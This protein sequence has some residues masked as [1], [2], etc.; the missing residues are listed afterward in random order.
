MDLVL[1]NAGNC[2]RLRR[3]KL[4]GFPHHAL[5][6]Y[7]PKLV[8]AVTGFAVAINWKDPSFVKGM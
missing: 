7:L 8:R 2:F 6:T 3:V 1:T 5:D 4:G